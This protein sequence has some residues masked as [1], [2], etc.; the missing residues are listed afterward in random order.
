MFLTNRR[1]CNELILK[2]SCF[3]E[4]NSKIE[5]LFALLRFFAKFYSKIRNFT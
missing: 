2:N 4:N 1:I 5:T 3:F